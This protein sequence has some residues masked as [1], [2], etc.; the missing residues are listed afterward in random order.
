MEIIQRYNAGSR[1]F[2]A[3]TLD[4]DVSKHLNMD[5]MD[6][7]GLENLTVQKGKKGRSARRRARLRADRSAAHGTHTEDGLCQG[8]SLDNNALSAAQQHPGSSSTYRAQKPSSTTNARTQS[9]DIPGLITKS[10]SRP[11]LSANP[12]SEEVVRTIPIPPSV[13]ALGGVPPL[14]I[15]KW[16]RYNRIPK[17]H[18]LSVPPLGRPVKPQPSGPIATAISHDAD[19][20]PRRASI[21]QS[22]VTALS[23]LHSGTQPEQ[24]GPNLRGRDFHLSQHDNST[25]EV[26]AQCTLQSSSKPGN[27]T[28]PHSKKR[29]LV[30]GPVPTADYLSIAEIA[31]KVA[32]RPQHLLLVLDLNGTL[33]YRQKA[34]SS[35]SPRP[36]LQLFLDYC[37]ANHSVLVW[38]SATPP[39]VRAVCSQIFPQVY[40]QK[41]LG[42]WGRDT[43][44]LTSD[45]YK[46][47]TQ[48]Y[49]R[50]DRIWDGS[51]LHYAHPDADNGRRWSQADTLLLDDSL[52]KAQAQPFNLVQIPEFTREG[53][54][55]QQEKEQQ[56]LQ[57]VVTYLEIAR[58]YEN[59]SAFVRMKRFVI[60]ASPQPEWMRSPKTGNDEIN[61]GGLRAS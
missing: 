9:G 12:R 6:T 19:R 47:K 10:L 58:M 7:L 33:I 39:N 44:E 5:N 54:D 52:I 26:S 24:K 59:V 55:G 3:A 61:D 40:R 45:E 50:L 53:R 49:K 13:P 28:T 48:V 43:L 42:E 34:S 4:D 17:Y 22:E 11:A 46:A 25:V 41:L 38:S 2:D 16:H 20:S 1:P 36:S 27:I 15:D 30:S 35:Y 32:S 29:K 14:R 56:V 37:F 21:L 8:R 60:G 18:A 57:Q 23:T 51:A 31:P